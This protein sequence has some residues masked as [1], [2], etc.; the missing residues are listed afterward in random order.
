[1]TVVYQRKND[2]MR[3]DHPAGL[4][5]T[6]RHRATDDH[7]PTPSEFAWPPTEDVIAFARVSQL[8]AEARLRGTATTT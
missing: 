7:R 6:N 3:F 5:D 2:W 1:M 8:A 4:I